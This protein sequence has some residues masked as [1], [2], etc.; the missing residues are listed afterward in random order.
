LEIDH[1]PGSVSSKPG[2]LFIRHCRQGDPLKV[3]RIEVK[4]RGGQ[5]KTM[6]VSF[7]TRTD[8]EKYVN[9]FHPEFLGKETLGS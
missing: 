8:L 1:P 9:R 2:K 3:L 5:T 4:Y 6:P 7:R